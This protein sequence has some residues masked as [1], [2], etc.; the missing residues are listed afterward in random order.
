MERAVAAICTNSV[1]EII[2]GVPPRGA[3]WQK[4]PDGMPAP[5]QW[6]G[7]VRGLPPD[8]VAAFGRSGS[9]RCTVLC[10]AVGTVETVVAVDQ[11][12]PNER[13]KGLEARA[14]VRTP[15]YVRSLTLWGP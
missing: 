6:V 12:H 4:S 13:K 11:N 1:A 15:A 9:W 7:H 2:Y 14:R 10:V 5:R 8:T 3:T